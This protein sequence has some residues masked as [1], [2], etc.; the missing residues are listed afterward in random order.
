MMYYEIEIWPMLHSSVK[1]RAF[2]LN[3]NCCATRE[4]SGLI[5]TEWR[6]KWKSSLMSAILCFLHTWKCHIQCIEDSSVSI[7]L[8][9]C[10]NKPLNRYIHFVNSNLVVFLRPVGQHF[11]QVVWQSIPPSDFQIENKLVLKSIKKFPAKIVVIYNRFFCQKLVSHPAFS[12]SHGKEA[13]YECV[14]SPF[15]K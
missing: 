7:W 6:W 4:T 15:F 13:F 11:P 3:M 12:H 8:R 5:H 2:A 1:K 9:L 14:S 10:V